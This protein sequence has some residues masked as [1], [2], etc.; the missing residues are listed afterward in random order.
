MSENNQDFTPPD[1]PFDLFAQWFDLAERHEVNDPNAMSL[2][3]VGENG[4]PSL[5]VMLMK[6]HDSRGFVFFTNYMSKKG[7]QLEK[8]NKAAVGFHWKSIRRQVIAEGIVNKITAEESDAYFST[9]PRG[10]Q[11]GA[12]ASKQSMP[13]SGRKELEARVKEVEVEFQGKEVPR[14]PHWGGFRISPLRIEFW[15]DR[16]FRLHDRI[17]YTRTSFEDAWTIGR[18]NP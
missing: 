8:H 18:I 13:L 1:A 4:M 17:I 14:P 12:W 16:P 2:A 10:S 15:Q 3:T 7:Q 5:R 11:I 6:M 9:R